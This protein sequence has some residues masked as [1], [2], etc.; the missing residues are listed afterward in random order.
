MSLFFVGSMGGRSR[1]EAHLH[2]ERVERSALSESVCVQQAGRLEASVLGEARKDALEVEYALENDLKSFGKGFT[3][4]EKA[5]AV[6]DWLCAWRPCG[7]VVQRP[8]L[9]LGCCLQE[10]FPHHQDRM[11]GPVE[12]FRWVRTLTEVLLR[13]GLAGHAAAR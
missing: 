9:K 11:A 10:F 5:R 7:R 4:L 3:V 2:D 1:A 12:S 8:A 6:G 13:A